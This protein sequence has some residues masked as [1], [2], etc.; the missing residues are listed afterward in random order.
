MSDV[1]RHEEES[2]LAEVKGLLE[3]V[4]AWG[5]WGRMLVAVR[6]ARGS[7]AVE[8]I[9]VEE[10]TGDDAEL[11]AAFTSPDARACLPAL[12]KA[13]EALLLLEGASPE[14]LGGGT[15][16][17]TR[18][19]GVAFLAGLVRAPSRALDGRRDRVLAELRG[20][21]RVLKERYGVG[22]GADL[23]TDMVTGAVSVRRGG[24]LVATGEQVVIGSFSVADRS[25]VWG[26]HNPTLE[27]AARG[28]CAAL[29]DAIADRSA[30]ELT[31]AGF[32]TDEATAWAL[33]AFVAC[34][35]R[36]DGVV[37]LPAGDEG[38]VLL[39]LS[40]LGPPT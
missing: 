21:N 2:I 39:G 12:A 37:R 30:W 20:M 23:D 5:S 22:G 36:L 3:Q 24:S 26:A 33:A 8:D 31:T 14:R 38:F 19:D 28:R 1:H 9:L 4:F 40:G 10:V 35:H 18:E 27:V 32:V 29:L 13:V 34:E 16:V 11:D 6:A 17:R 7:W 25:W 15:F